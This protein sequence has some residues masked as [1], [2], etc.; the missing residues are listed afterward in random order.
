MKENSPRFSPR[1]KEALVAVGWYPGRAV[2]DEQ[3]AEWMVQ[4]W[5]YEKDYIYQVR[6]FSTAWHVL[7]EFGDLII[8]QD[9]PGESCYREDIVFNPTYGSQSRDFAVGVEKWFMCEWGIRSPLFP[10]GY[11]KESPFTELGID[12]YGR[13]HSP[14]HFTIYGQTI[15]EALENLVIGRTP[16][17]FEEEQTEDGGYES[18]YMLPML[19]KR[20]Q[21][22]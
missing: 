16:E 21:S 13:I 14:D 6:M 11:I 22:N 19:R 7:R 4:N 3:M 10:I 9:A 12:I 18:A 17:P 8:R 2:A 20:F 1:V 5:K 15:E